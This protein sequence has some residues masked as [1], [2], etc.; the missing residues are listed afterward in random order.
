MLKLAFAA[1]VSPPFLQ[2]NSDA[3][4]AF[5]RVKCQTAQTVGRIT[6]RRI[7]VSK[8][9]VKEYS[10]SNALENHILLHKNSMSC[11]PNFTVQIKP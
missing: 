10:F 4:P 8:C 3:A 1:A 7:R 5:E 9:N 2:S 11:P 6:I